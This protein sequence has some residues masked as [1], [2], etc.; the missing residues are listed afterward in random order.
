MKNK[1]IDEETKLL[2]E[3]ILNDSRIKSFSIDWKEMGEFQGD[4]IRPVVKIEKS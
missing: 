4:D 1:I 3:E 2:I